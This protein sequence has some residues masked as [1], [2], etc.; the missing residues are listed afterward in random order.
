MFKYIYYDGTIQGLIQETY[1]NLKEIKTEHQ[2]PK[3]FETIIHK[4]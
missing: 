3:S 1:N 2:M 4:K